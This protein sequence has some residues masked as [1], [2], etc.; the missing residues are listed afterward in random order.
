MCQRTIGCPE[1]RRSI[2]YV[3]CTASGASSH[4]QNSRTSSCCP[5]NMLCGE[6]NIVV[7]TGPWPSGESKHVC[8]LFASP[9]EPQGTETSCTFDQAFALETSLES[10]VQSQLPTDSQ[11]QHSRFAKTC[12]RIGATRYLGT[13]PC[14]GRCCAVSQAGHAIMVRRDA[15]LAVHG[16]AAVRAPQWRCPRS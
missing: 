14:K 13:P 9:T 7:P 3:R 1:R 4:T 16:M 11:V 6:G 8:V 15:T 10:Q 12:W 2:Q 5:K